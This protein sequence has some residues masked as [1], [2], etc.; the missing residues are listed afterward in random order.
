[1]DITVG[2][3]GTEDEDYTGMSNVV[4]GGAF[5]PGEFRIITI[6]GFTSGGGGEA[7]DRRVREINFA[8]FPDTMLGETGSFNSQSIRP[9]SGHVASSNAKTTSG[10]TA[11]YSKTLVVTNATG[12]SV[13]DFVFDATSS[14][15]T[16]RLPYNTTVTGVSGT[17][18]TLSHPVSESIPDGDT[19]IRIGPSDRDSFGWDYEKLARETN[20]AL[21][22]MPGPHYWSSDN[23]IGDSSSG[24]GVSST[25]ATDD[26]QTIAIFQTWKVTFGRSIGRVFG[27]Y[28]FKTA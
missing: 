3:T 13:G 5:T 27:Q 24:P 28:L 4:I 14:N 1:M 15:D 10:V 20:G 6:D 12:I 7:T 26:W 21:Y 9:V 8:C 23:E 25:Q 19:N 22:F 2:A 17:T 18:L 16:L 11:Q